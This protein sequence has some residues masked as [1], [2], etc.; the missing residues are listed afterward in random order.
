MDWITET[1]A[2]GNRQDAADRALLGREKI[3]AVLALVADVPDA[4]SLG[5]EE[6]V[7]VPMID[8]AGNDPGLFQRV[9]AILDRLE[10][11]RAPVLVHCHAGRSRSVVVVAGHLMRRLGIDADEALERVSA[12]REIAISDGLDRLLDAL[13]AG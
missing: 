10:R 13:E 9:L 12:K 4:A 1:I 2:I 3:R 6:L 5:V 11:E 8:G 7:S